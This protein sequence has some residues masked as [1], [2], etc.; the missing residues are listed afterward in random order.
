ME[1]MQLATPPSIVNVVDF[2]QMIR[3]NN[4]KFGTKKIKTNLFLIKGLDTYVN[5]S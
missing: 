5:M 4:Y 1:A 3:A 2:D